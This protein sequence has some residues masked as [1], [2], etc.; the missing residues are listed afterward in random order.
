MVM[1]SSSSHITLNHKEVLFHY[2]CDYWVSH[3]YIRLQLDFH[4][5]GDMILYALQGTNIPET[6]TFLSAWFQV[7]VLMKR[8]VF[9]LT[10]NGQTQDGQVRL[11]H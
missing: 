6:K 7:G 5:I 11:S 8:I 3:W 9:E 4:W 2:S 10:L 1:M